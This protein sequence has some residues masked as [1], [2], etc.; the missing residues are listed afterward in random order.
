[1]EEGKEFILVS[2]RHRTR[3][4]GYKLWD[5]R[6]EL[7]LRKNFLKSNGSKTRWSQETGIFNQPG[8]SSRQSH[9][10]ATERGCRWD[11]MSRGSL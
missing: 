11:L 2:L 4:N 5:E 6:Y 9:S 7:S 3:T 1:M 8:L 10:S